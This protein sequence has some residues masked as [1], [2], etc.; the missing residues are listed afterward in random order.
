[1]RRAVINELIIDTG[2]IRYRRCTNAKH[3]LYDRG[4]VSS[5]RPKPW[6]W[7]RPKP[8]QSKTEVLSKKDGWRLKP[9]RLTEAFNESSTSDNSWK[10][11][12]TSTF[13]E[14]WGHKEKDM[15]STWVEKCLQ[16]QDTSAFGIK[17]SDAFKITN[18][19]TAQWRNSET[20]VTKVTWSIMKQLLPFLLVKEESTP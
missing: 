20:M 9:Y 1:M 19:F 18:Q 8:Y 12:A 5:R 14:T 11:Y 10:I 17:M 13:T 15:P 6:E 3:V 16:W 4:L 7:Q 2:M